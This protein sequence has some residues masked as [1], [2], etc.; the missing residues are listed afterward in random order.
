MSDPAAAGQVIAVTGTGTVVGPA[1]G[2]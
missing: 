2:S 1:A